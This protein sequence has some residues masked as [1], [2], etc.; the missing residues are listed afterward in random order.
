VNVEF[1]DSDKYPSLL[2]YGISYGSKRFVA[3]GPGTN[4]INLFTTV[5]YKFLY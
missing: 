2:Q 4:P 3:Q 5:I 1:S